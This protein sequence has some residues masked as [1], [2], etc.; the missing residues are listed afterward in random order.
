M[1]KTCCCLCAVLAVLVF[2]CGSVGSTVSKPAMIADRDPFSLGSVNASLERMFTGQLRETAVNVIFYPRLNQVALEFRHDLLTNRQFWNE[3]A[4]QQYITALGLYNEDFENKNLVDSYRKSRAAYGKNTLRYEWETFKYSATYR[5]SP[6]IE[7][8]YRFKGTAVY[9]TVFQRS[10]Q[11]DS[12]VSGRKND[13]PQY[14]IYFTRAQ[15]EELAKLFDQAY[16]L[17]LVGSQSPSPSGD[18]AGRD[19]YIP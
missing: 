14:S 5:S 4:R 12:S 10:V 7:L 6:P 1:R 9:F 15:A 17:E 8:G 16:L 18:A 11:E 3:A 13:S 2:S 19:I